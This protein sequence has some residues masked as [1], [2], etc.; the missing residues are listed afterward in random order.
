[1]IGGDDFQGAVLEAGDN[2]LHVLLGAQRRGHLV[3]AVEVAQ[4]LV[5]EGE[6]MRRG[7]A[8]DLDAASAGLA[9]QF[10]TA[11]GGDVQDAQPAAGQ[12]GQ[13]DIPVDHDLLGRGRHAS[14]SQPHAL[15]SL[16]HNAA[17]GQL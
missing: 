14:Q 3:V 8:A 4:A 9:N 2:G 17:A 15:K 13:G 12:L 1:M 11:R 10:D 6:M 16:M 5:G 7:F